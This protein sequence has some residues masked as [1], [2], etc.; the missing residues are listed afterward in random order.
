MVKQKSLDI[1]A[2]CA[3]DRICI[4]DSVYTQVG[5]SACY[6][7]YTAREF[8]WDVNLYTK[9]GSDFPNKQYLDTHDIR[10]DTSICIT[11]SPTTQFKI[12]VQQ[13]ADRDLY[14]EHKCDTIQFTPQTKKSDIAIVSPI[15]DEISPKTFTEIKQSYDTTFLD[16]QG[17]LRRTGDDNKIFL[18]KTS[19]DLA[20][21]FAIKVNPQE[22]NQLIPNTAAAGDTVRDMQLLQ[23]AGVRYVLHTNKTAVS[24]LDG[25][26]LYSLKLPNKNI[27]DTTGIGDIFSAVFLCTALKEKDSLWALCF[28]AGAAQAALETQSVGLEK[29][30]S[31]GAV[32]TNASYFYNMLDF[33]QI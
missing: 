12:N 31:R 26:R 32:S 4:G 14:L 28:A 11:N 22:M 23:K 29:V 13:D 10:Y 6:C 17:F 7:A 25:D 30:P 19:L 21:V 27:H 3:Q 8:K 18:S 24:M 33:R 20:G 5:G 16:P 9:F 1:Y 15:Y 2:N